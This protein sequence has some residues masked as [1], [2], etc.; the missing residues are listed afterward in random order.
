[1][2]ELDRYKQRTVKSL[3]LR[4]RGLKSMPLGV[5]SNFRFYDPYPIFIDHAAGSR[6]WDADGNEYIDYALSFGALMAGHSHPAVVRAIERQASRGLMFGMP[7]AMMLDLAEELMGRFGMERVRFGNS[8]TEATMHALRV[9]RGATGRKRILKFEGGYHG[10]HDAVL[11]AVKPPAGKSGD[12]RRP[13]SVPASKGIPDEVSALTIAATF[14]DIESVKGAFAQ[15]RGEIAALI[16]EPIMMNIGV[17]EPQPGFLEALRDICTKEGTVLIFDEVKT[18]SKLAP[19]GATEHYRIQPDLITMAKSFGGGAPIAAFG[20]R[21]DLM[22]SIERFEVFHA[23]TYNAGPLVVAAAIAALKEV[24]TPDAFKGVRELNRQLVEGHAQII[25]ETGLPAHSTGIGANGCVYFTPEPVRNYRD[26]QRV[27]KE[28][29]WQYWFAM[30]NRG[31]IPG[32]QYYDE[33]WTVSVAHTAADVDRTLSAF[34]E[35][36]RELRPSLSP[37]R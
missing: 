20:G 25:K 3:A 1:M 7:N 10:A 13:L 32:G 6:V 28:L 9:A 15:Y 30:L 18:G 29:F 17:C 34:A 31:I 21:A 5:E 22:A 19:G 2:T 36:A 24:L 23:G 27:D 35:V 8:G 4:E 14:N 12:L 26:F 11:V 33:Q 37:A 16:L